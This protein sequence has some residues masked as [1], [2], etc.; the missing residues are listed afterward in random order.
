MKKN[1]LPNKKDGDD[2]NVNMSPH[3]FS[4][5]DLLTNDETSKV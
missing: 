3:K 4:E 5:K 2:I 1:Y